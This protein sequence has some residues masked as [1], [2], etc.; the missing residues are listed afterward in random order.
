MRKKTAIFSNTTNRRRSRA[1]MTLTEVL[2]ASFLL[3]L[4]MTAIARLVT[5]LSAA[6][7]MSGNVTAAT[8][9]AQQKLEELLTVD[10]AS[11][12]SGADQVDAFDRTWTVV[13]HGAEAKEV[14]VEI[15]WR[16]VMGVSRDMSLQSWVASRGRSTAPLH[17]FT[18]IPSL[19]P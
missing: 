19:G 17:M 10:F 8:E 12:Q 16:D 13:A 15:V 6:S 5:V 11:V 14:V 7:I 18:N 1:G 4:G 3:V 2:V 9:L